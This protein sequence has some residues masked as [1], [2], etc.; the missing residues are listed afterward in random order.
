MKKNKVLYQIRSL[1]KLIIRYFSKKVNIKCFS[2]IP[3]P[4][5]MQIIDY[6][7]EHPTEDIYQKDLEEILN[8]RRATVSGVLKT[9][10]K[11][12]LLKRIIHLEDARTK[13]IILN[14]STRE[15]FIQNEKYLKELE[16]NLTYN[17]TED[18]LATFSKVV[19]TMKQ[20]LTALT[21]E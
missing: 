8:L 19:D 12:G 4:T 5:Q 6:I 1:E 21:K 11:N 3:T 9:M 13:K 7:M 14:D 17:L 18:E 2:I 16:K 20:N 15:I 10:E